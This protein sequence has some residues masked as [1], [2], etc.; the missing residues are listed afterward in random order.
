M[1]KC[2][3]SRITVDNSRSGLIE[4]PVENEEVKFSFS[5]LIK[6]RFN[7]K[8]TTFIVYQILRSI[9][10]YQQIPLFLSLDTIASTVI[11]IAF[12]G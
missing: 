8:K 5:Q 7:L 10:V 11:F 2:L 12:S 6:S 3:I 1:I 9:L 4:K